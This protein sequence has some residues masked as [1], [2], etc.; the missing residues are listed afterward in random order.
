M[1][2]RIQNKSSIFLLSISYLGYTLNSSYL[3]LEQDTITLVFDSI[4]IV[5][6]NIF[7]KH[8]EVTPTQN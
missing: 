5:W 4:L 6:A 7:A 3:M 8:N 2:Y 1:I